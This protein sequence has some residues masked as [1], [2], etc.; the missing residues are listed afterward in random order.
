MKQIVSVAI[1]SLLILSAPTANA[2]PPW[3]SLSEATAIQGFDPVAYFTKGAAIRGSSK[4]SQDFQ[5][6]SWFFSSA[7]NRDAFTADPE[8]YIPQFGGFCTV[9]IAGGKNAKGSGEAWTIHDGKLYLNF[10]KDVMA[11]FRSDAS[12]YVTKASGW[13]STVKSRIENQ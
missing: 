10:N 11:T 6:V 12:G 2:V 9:S 13:W 3:S 1:A 8:K 4:F 7:E 5:G